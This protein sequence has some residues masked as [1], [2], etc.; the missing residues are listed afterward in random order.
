M[1]LRFARMHDCHNDCHESKHSHHRTRFGT[2]TQL[3]AGNLYDDA[4]AWQPGLPDDAD[5]EEIQAHERAKQ[6]FDP[7]KYFPSGT[8]AF[9]TIAGSDGV[10]T[11][12]FDK[13]AQSVSELRN[14]YKSAAMVDRSM[15]STKDGTQRMFGS[16]NLL[17]PLSHPPSASLHQ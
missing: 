11:D 8:K 14:R 3:A 9:D 12:C 1:H 2:A 16:E 4:G 5:D 13:Q 17:R 6:S 10:E 15:V 7:A